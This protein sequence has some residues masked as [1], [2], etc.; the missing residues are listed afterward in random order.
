M[1][2]GLFFIY[3]IFF[4]QS[5]GLLGEG[6]SPSQGR[7]LHTG[8]RKH[9]LNAHTDIRALSEIRIHDRSVQ[10]SEDSWCL[11]SHD[12]CDRQYSLNTISKVKVRC[13]SKATGWPYHTSNWL[14]TA[15]AR[16]RARV[17]SFEICGGQSA[18]GAGFLWV[19]PFPLPIF[20]PPV[21]PQ[22][23]S[24]IIW[25]WYNRPVVAAV[26]SGLSLNPLRIIIKQQM[27]WLQ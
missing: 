21:A 17:W 10:T 27:G 6:I 7:W 19:R 18:A 16:V 3:V 15:A 9:R 12:H 8:Q 5:V 14:H 26:P 23:P 1:G 24:S 2:P 11:R 13:S 4:T 22:L 20:I 25:D